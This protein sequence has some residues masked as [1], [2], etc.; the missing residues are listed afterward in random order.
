VAQHEV[1]LRS[2]AVPAYV[3]ALLYGIGQGA[4][5]PV[6]ALTARDLGA[7]VGLAGLVVALLGVGQILGDVPAGAIASRIGERAAML[8]AVAVASTAL[9]VCLTAGRLLA[10]GPAVL[11]LGASNSVFAL[12][13]QSFLTDVIPVRLRARAL[14]TLGGTLRVGAFVGPFV[15][16]PVIGVLGTDGAYVVHLVVALVVAVVLLTLREP[17]H[18]SHAARGGDPVPIGEVVRSHAM[19]LRTLG[20]SGL[21]IGAVRASRQVVI[22]LWAQQMGLDPVT[23]SIVYGLSGMIDAVLFYPSGRVM[24]VHG[25]AAV[26]VPSMLTLGV[27]HLL[28]PLA[29]DEAS[30]IA[31]A[32]L[33]GV[34]NGLGSGVV[35]TLGADASPARG[36]AEFLGVWRIFHDSGM[37]GGPLVLSAV[38]GLAGLAPAVLTMGAVGLVSSGLLARWI[39]RYSRRCP[40]G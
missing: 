4:V 18:L 22:P 6:V 16:A 27:A 28:L 12:A 11:V 37:A 24:D 2:V 40:S 26:A 10:L 30:L 32:L 8:L 3:P 31:V 1:T 36:R 9:V 13:R 39:P 29:G 15:A 38:A 34:G 7:S 35:M 33:M 19:V 21:L 20:V 14:S 17:E 25:R 5:A 23:T